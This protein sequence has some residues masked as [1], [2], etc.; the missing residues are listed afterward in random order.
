MFST[1]P[2]LGASKIV[3]IWA[4]AARRSLAAAF[5]LAFCSIIEV[6]SASGRPNAFLL[7][8]TNLETFKKL[9]DF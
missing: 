3:A 1:N 6:P 2:G 7:F 4:I 8:L 5:C 9:K